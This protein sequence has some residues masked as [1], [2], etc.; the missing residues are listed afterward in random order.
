M[1][2]QWCMWQLPEAPRRAE[3]PLAGVTEGQE[4]TFIEQLQD[5][6]FSMLS[7]LCLATW[8]KCHSVDY[9]TGEEPR[10]RNLPGP[11]KWWVDTRTQV[12]LSPE[13]NPA[14]RESCDEA[15]PVN[16]LKDEY[17]FTKRG[18]W[19]GV[20]K[21]WR[22]D[23]PRCWQ[24]SWK[25]WPQEPRRLGRGHTR[26]GKAPPRATCCPLWG[27][28]AGWGSPCPSI[29]HKWR[30]PPTSLLSIQANSP[31]YADI[32]PKRSAPRKT[33]TWSYPL[34]PTDSQFRTMEPTQNLRWSQASP[35]SEWATQ[36]PHCHPS[37][38]LPDVKSWG[39]DLAR[40]LGP[41]GK[42]GEVPWIW[43]IICN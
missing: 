43:A 23:R 2:P 4:G 26:Q 35:I 41:D 29:T 33:G 40:S 3:W 13:S 37:L 28:G 11:P 30:A 20:A 19:V 9:S 31:N 8:G 42:E 16:R 24:G 38:G 10:L 39:S 18:V 17:P 36:S 32:T 15:A 22:C 7:P 12:C 21:W 6:N 25:L 34:S 14:H 27:H 5:S 1:L